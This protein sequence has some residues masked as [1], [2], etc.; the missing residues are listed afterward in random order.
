M[1]IQFINSYGKLHEYNFIREVVPGENI[2]VYSDTGYAKFANPEVEQYYKENNIRLVR[3]NDYAK[4]N[5][6]TI[7]SFFNLLSGIRI[8]LKSRR[9]K[10]DYCF[11]HFLSTRRAILSYFVPSRTKQVLITY[12]SDLLRRNNFNNFFFKKMIERSHLIVFNSG[13]LRYTFEQAYGKQ[14]ENKC[15]DIAF[16]CASFDRLETLISGF[17][18]EDAF[19]RFNL[20][21]DKKI[22]VCGHTS[23]EDEQFEP[24]I[25]ALSRINQ[26][27]KDECYFVFFMTYG[28]GNYL[29]YRKRVE[30]KLKATDLN[31][32]IL[33]D[34]LNYDEMAL[35]HSVSNIHI[36][37]ITTDALSIFL[38]EEMYA[39]ATVLYGKWLHYIEFENEDYGAI[40]YND[41]DDLTIKFNEVAS[42]NI[43]PK[44]T[45]LKHMI[46]NLSSNESISNSW[47]KILY[48]NE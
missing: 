29:E 26:T 40:P 8:I 4:I 9:E 28:S 15:V 19:K 41:F 46:E 25:D 45:N 10:Y 13:N 16:P 47:R 17:K 18:P 38:Q 3:A 23:T 43:P 24:M 36:T 2:T 35:L 37:S 30:D 39:G 42:G 33:K 44:P 27:S 20:P 1:K 6:R 11:V 12:G 34:Y 14:Y 5:N 32:T 22:V 7:R 48:G 31:F 21:S